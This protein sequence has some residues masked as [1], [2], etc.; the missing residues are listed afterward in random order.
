[1][2]LRPSSTPASWFSLPGI[3]AGR[4]LRDAKLSA[5]GS[6]IFIYD[7]YYESNSLDRKKKPFKGVFSLD[8]SQLPDAEWTVCFATQREPNV[9]QNVPYPLVSETNGIFLVREKP[10][11]KYLLP[12][13]QQ[14]DFGKR[15]SGI[16]NG[17]DGNPDKMARCLFVLNSWDPDC[18]A[19]SGLN[20]TEN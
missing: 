10:S 15:S 8:L 16:F 18:R 17:K 9:H 12:L 4:H 11:R 14:V 3:P 1:M 19:D 6:T 2:N 5:S 13:I 20:S 7:G